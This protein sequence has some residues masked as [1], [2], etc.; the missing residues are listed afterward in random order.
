[1]FAPPKDSSLFAYKRDGGRG[2]ERDAIAGASLLRHIG[3]CARHASPGS[4]SRESLLAFLVLLLSLI[5]S[6]ADSPA[7]Y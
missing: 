7:D 5:E 6:H 2:R 1:M 4:E 3:Q